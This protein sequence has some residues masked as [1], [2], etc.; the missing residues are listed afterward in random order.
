MQPGKNSNDETAHCQFPGNKE[1]LRQEL[2]D[3]VKAGTL[4]ARQINMCDAESFHTRFN[5]ESVYLD[6]HDELPKGPRPVILIM[7]DVPSIL[8]PD[9]VTVGIINPDTLAAYKENAKTN[10]LKKNAVKPDELLVKCLPDHRSL[11]RR[12][13]EK[14]DCTHPKYRKTTSG[15]LL[16]NGTFKP[17]EF[18]EKDYEQYKCHSEWLTT[19]YKKSQIKCFI[20]VKENI[21]KSITEH[22]Q[23]KHQL[24]EV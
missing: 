12:L 1:Q 5:N 20:S 16:K 19:G 24:E 21:D 15:H 10:A 18:R 11:K 17:P 6:H 23:D 4:G 2:L 13:L 22:L 7:E 3:A 8:R 9:H 14:A